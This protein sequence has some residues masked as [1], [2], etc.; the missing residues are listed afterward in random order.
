M[1]VSHSVYVHSF[2]LF[3]MEWIGE[4]RHSSC[5]FN[6]PV[7]GV[8]MMDVSFPYRSGEQAVL[9]RITAPNS[10]LLVAIVGGNLM[11]GGI[12]KIRQK[13]RGRQEV[14][15]KVQGLKGWFYNVLS[16]SESFVSD[17]DQYEIA[18]GIFAEAL[19]LAGAPT[20]SVSAA[21]AV[22][23]DRQLTVKAWDS[24]GDIIDALAR[25]SG[26]FEWGVELSAEGSSVSASV[27]MYPA[28]LP[29]LSGSRVIFDSRIR[30]GRSTFGE[31]PED[32]SNESSWAW[33]LGDGAPPE[34]LYSY[35][36]SPMLG[37][38][39]SPVLRLETATTYNGVTS[40]DTLTDHA[41]YDRLHSRSPTIVI[42][43]D[44]PPDSPSVFDYRSG[45]RCRV[46]IEDGWDSIDLT[47]ARIIDRAMKASAGQATVATASVDLNDSVDSSA[48]ET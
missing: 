18:S 43:I 27:V 44:H 46:R 16:Q 48:Q 22:G 32:N 8:P 19:S 3:S 17:T 10:V 41:I 34:Q 29:R 33:A 30:Y 39:D 35:N 11:F 2:D 40:V 4:V 42:P 45:D 23:P 13:T 26:G 5:A 24:Y 21:P 38:T 6:D 9:K 15:L 14:S 7:D 20:I 36:A 12:P 31:T 25:R 37:D 1:P 47:G 28:G